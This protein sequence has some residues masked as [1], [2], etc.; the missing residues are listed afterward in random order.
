MVSCLAHLGK[1][2]RLLNSDNELHA[3]L[4]GSD[5]AGEC[6]R[7]ANDLLL[8]PTQ[9]SKRRGELRRNTLHLHLSL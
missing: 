5:D 3:Q 4:R 7:S 9:S 1:K 6:G 2:N 8:Q